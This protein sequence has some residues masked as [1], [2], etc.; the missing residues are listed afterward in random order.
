MTV[1]DLLHLGR[2]RWYIFALGLVCAV[3]GSLILKAEPWTYVARTEFVMISPA[4]S[5]GVVIPE[6]TRTSLISFADVVTRKFNDEEPTHT[7]SSPSATLFGN[8]IRKGSS[9]KLLNSGTQWQS[10]FAG[11]VISVQVV[12]ST[13]AQVQNELDSIASRIARITKDVQDGRG[14]NAKTY[15]TSEVD[16]TRIVISAFGPT[17]TSRTKGT[18]LLIAC[19]LGISMLVARAL[20]TWD[21][22]RMRR[23][24]KLPADLQIRA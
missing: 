15:I 16:P 9:V 10:S 14:I 13:E 11:P 5:A 21:L 17:R 18:L 24:A 4:N 2:R 8:G 20:D 19:A 23:Q 7:L 22:R 12:G 3:T 1:K 6:D